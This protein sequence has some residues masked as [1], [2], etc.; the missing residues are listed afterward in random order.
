MNGY[1]HLSLRSALTTLCQGT[2]I[3]GAD[4]RCGLIVLALDVGGRFSPETAD[5]VQRLASVRARGVVSPTRGAAFAW[6]WPFFFF[7]LCA[8]PATA[9]TGFD[10][11]PP[12][13]SDVLTDGDER[14][15]CRA[16]PYPVKGACLHVRSWP[17]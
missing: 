13:V 3:P 5:F 11:P 9:A 1:I 10:G 6:R 17:L 15:F 12:L 4:S 14:A 8:L 2:R 7:S 16:Q